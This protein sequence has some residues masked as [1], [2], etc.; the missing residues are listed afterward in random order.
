MRYA[1][2]GGNIL[3]LTRCKLGQALKLQL[4]GGRLLFRAG[5]KGPLCMKPECTS[6]TVEDA[7]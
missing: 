1:L 5:S 3:Y 2:K 6:P 7:M 4:T